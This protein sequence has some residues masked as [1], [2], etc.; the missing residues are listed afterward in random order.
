MAK[1]AT[2]EKRKAGRPSLFDAMANDIKKEAAEPKTLGSH[3]PIG[4]GREPLPTF[5]EMSNREFFGRLRKNAGKNAYVMDNVLAYLKTQKLDYIEHS[6]IVDAL[7]KLDTKAFCDSLSD[8]GVMEH[9]V[10]REDLI[11][12][13]TRESILEYFVN[14]MKNR[15]YTE[16]KHAWDLILAMEGASPFNYIRAKRKIGK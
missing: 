12:K 8:A 9:V 3:A 16:Q 2:I 4:L 11:R 5:L 6:R 10:G 13:A 7:G 15:S 14:D 1:G